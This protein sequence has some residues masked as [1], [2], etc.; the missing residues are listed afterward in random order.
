MGPNEQ[1]RPNDIPAH[2]WFIGVLANG[3]YRFITPDALKNAEAYIGEHGGGVYTHAGY[4]V[5]AANKAWWNWLTKAYN[6]EYRFKPDYQR[7]PHIDVP[8]IECSFSPE[9]LKWLEDNEELLKKVGGKY[10]ENI[11]KH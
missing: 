6:K 10:Y 2:R 4:L 8:N 7:P 5:F 3:Q 11:P 1:Q 9:A